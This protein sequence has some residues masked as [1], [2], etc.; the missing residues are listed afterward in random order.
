MPARPKWP[1]PR[2]RRAASRVEADAVVVDAHPHRAVLGGQADRDPGGAGV[3]GDVV[4]GLLGDP[5][6]DGLE[7]GQEALGLLGLAA[8][9]AGAGPGQAVAQ[10]GQLLDRSVVEVGGQPDPLLLGRPQHRLR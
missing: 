8:L 3:L 7:F 4:E 9:D 1:S 2:R 5:V 10:G 6:Q